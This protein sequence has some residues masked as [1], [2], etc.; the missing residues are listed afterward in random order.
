MRATSVPSFWSTHGFR[1][2]QEAAGKGDVRFVSKFTSVQFLVGTVFGAIHCAAWNAHF[3]S[4]DEM[5]IWRSCSLVT[6]ATPLGVALLF[7]LAALGHAYSF[8]AKVLGWLGDF[9]FYII[10]VAYI[11]ARLLLILL[12]LTTL[13]ALPPDA[14][15]D[16]NWSIYILHL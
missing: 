12:S 13:R 5:L 8:N 7:I 1:G 2:S 14:F 9:V 10:V 4:A 11:G 6:V 16:V 15:V 3:P